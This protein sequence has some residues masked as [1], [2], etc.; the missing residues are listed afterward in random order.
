MNHRILARGAYG[1]KMD[2]KSNLEITIKW[3]CPG[4]GKMG[5]VFSKSDSRITIDAMR[6]NC[7]EHLL[8]VA[9]HKNH[10]LKCGGNI[11]IRE[12]IIPFSSR[13]GN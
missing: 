9:T 5:Y 1:A 7:E 13:K 10:N 8:A 2:E 6:R 3:R 12:V 4:C 11:G